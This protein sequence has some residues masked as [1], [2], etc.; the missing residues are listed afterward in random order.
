MSLELKKVSIIPAEPGYKTIFRIDQTKEFVIGDPIIAWRVDV[1]F[2]S[3]DG[4]FFCDSTPIDPNGDTIS[5]VSNCVA[6]QYPDGNIC[7]QHDADYESLEKLNE[8]WEW[9][10]LTKA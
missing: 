4:T 1:Y 8:I 3:E 9:E 7:F 6:I 5:S 2:N 10:P